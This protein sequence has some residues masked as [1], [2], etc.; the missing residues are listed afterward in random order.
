MLARVGG[1]A[2]ISNHSNHNI[3]SPKQMLQIL[4]IAL[5]PIKAGNKSE[6]LLNE[7]GQIINFYVE[8]KNY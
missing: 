7:I 1:V 6:N 4:P 8:Q 2:K 5:T 3:L